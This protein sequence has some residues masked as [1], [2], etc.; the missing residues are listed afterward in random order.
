MCITWCEFYFDVV[1]LFFDTKDK[2]HSSRITYLFL[3][4]G[5]LNRSQSDIIEA[6]EYV[7]KKRYFKDLSCQEFLKI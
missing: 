7:D 4:N 6:K 3:I 1:V 2:R 5:R